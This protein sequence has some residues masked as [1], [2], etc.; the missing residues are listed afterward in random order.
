LEP[1][2]W[3]QA[4]IGEVTGSARIPSFIVHRYT[5]DPVGF[6]IE[7]VEAQFIGDIEADKDTT[8]EACGETEDVY[9]GK[10]FFPEEVAE[11]QFEIVPDHKP[12]MI[13]L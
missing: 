11:G 4:C 12:M 5:D 13:L 1:G 9:K 3:S 10:D 6:G 8:D 2:A 7:R